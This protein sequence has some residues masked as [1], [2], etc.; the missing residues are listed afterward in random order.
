MNQENSRL[1]YFLEKIRPELAKRGYTLDRQLN[2]PGKRGVTGS[3]I[4]LAH[5]DKK[6]RVLK[7]TSHHLLDSFTGQ[8][9]VKLEDFVRRERIVMKQVGNH[10]NMPD[11]YGDFDI[12]Y[13]EK[14]NGEIW[15]D[16]VY[17]LD[18]EHLNATPIHQRI[19][20]GIKL[21][22]DEGKLT[23]Q[24]GLSASGHLHTGLTE[25]AIHRDIRPG[26][27]YI[28]GERAYLSDFEVVNL[29]GRDSETQILNP[30]YPL[31]FFSGI[32]Q[33]PSQDLVALGNVVIAGGL[34]KTIG[35][36]R[37][38]QILHG[39]GPVDISGL[40]YSDPLKDFLKKLTSDPDE[41]FQ[42]ANEALEGLERIMGGSNLP[43]KVDSSSVAKKGGKSAYEVIRDLWESPPFTDE[44]REI[45]IE[46]YAN[47]QAHLR[48]SERLERDM[49]GKNLFDQEEYEARR[50]AVRDYVTESAKAGDVF[51]QRVSEGKKLE[52]IVKEAIGKDS[53]MRLLSKKARQEYRE[54]GESLEGFFEGEKVRSGFGTSLIK[55]Y[56]GEFVL[57]G[58][59]G[60][61][62]G[63]VGGITVSGGHK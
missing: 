14:Y 17:I 38:E 45:K 6:S 62:L 50:E 33:N 20:E 25:I 31:D 37:T 28:N 51:F 36:I 21:S 48:V 59:V 7:M 55:Y 19:E 26:N 61:I 1:P 22:E 11:Y 56:Y 24:G 35:E 52:G 63:A 8:E 16:T 32:D 58:T 13:E 43:M 2:Q 27:V 54:A 4:W 12:D 3:M 34:G 49:I 29:G 46:K 15:K 30:Y 42:T 44:E 10:P 5:K 40:H 53:W 9:A 60:A 18:M 47:E 57:G 41:R 39:L 23:L